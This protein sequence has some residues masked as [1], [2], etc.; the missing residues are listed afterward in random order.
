MSGI[1]LTLAILAPD[2][3]S[4]MDWPVWFYIILG[5]LLLLVVVVI[6]AAAAYVLSVCSAFLKQ[7][8]MAFR[9]VYQH[10][11]TAM[12]LTPVLLVGYLY[13]RAQVHPSAALSVTLLS[14]ALASYPKWKM[15][16]ASPAQP[17]GV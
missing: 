7:L 8:P 4:T 9:T 1:R 13:T 14:A 5:L 2:K 6:L 3:S 16:K 17:E 10:R 12:C 15:H 11:R